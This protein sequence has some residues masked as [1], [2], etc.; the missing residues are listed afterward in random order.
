[1]ESSP[2]E[3]SLLPVTGLVLLAAVVGTVALYQDPL[4]SS[5]PT[6]PTQHEDLAFQR[7]IVQARLWEDPFEAVSLHLKGKGTNVPNEGSHRIADVIASLKGLPV[8]ANLSVDQ[9]G[10]IIQVLSV[11]VAGA[12][13]ADAGELRL[14][15]RY[16]VVS[17][18]G[19]AGYVP[20]DEEHIHYFKIGKAEVEGEDQWWLGQDL[21]VPYEIY[22]RDIFNQRWLSSGGKT[23]SRD[24]RPADYIVVL[25]LRNEVL[26]DQP[27]TLLQ[28]LVCKLGSRGGKASQFGVIGPRNS[29]TLRKMLVNADTGPTLEP[30]W[31]KTKPIPIYS[32]WSEAPASNLTLYLKDKKQENETSREQVRR[33]FQK[34]G[35]ELIRPLHTDDR[36]AEE[37]VEELIRR[38][39]DVDEREG[40]HHIVLVSE[41]DTFYGRQVPLTLK[42]ELDDKRPSNPDRSGDSLEPHVTRFTYLRG[43]DGHLPSQEREDSDSQPAT[44]QAQGES[45]SPESM[46]ERPEG[47]SQLDYLRRLASKLE[48]K[49]QELLREGK[50]EIRAI[51]ILGSDVYDKL[52]ITQALHKSFPRALFFTTG[53]DAQF[54]HP[55]EYPWCRNLII[56]STFG[57]ELTPSI[58]NGIPPFRSSYQTSL[59]LSTLT[60]IGY[61]KVQD[62]AAKS[63]LPWVFSKD[64][65]GQSHLQESE[66]KHYFLGRPRIFEIGRNGPFDLSLPTSESELKKVTAMEPVLEIHPTRHDTFPGAVVVRWFLLEVVALAL[67]ILLLILALC[68]ALKDRLVARCYPRPDG[69]VKTIG[70]SLG[71][72]L[73]FVV[74]GFLFWNTDL[75][76]QDEPFSFTDG[77]SIWP[78]EFLR[79]VVVLASVLLMV[80]AK[81]DLLGNDRDVAESFGLRKRGE[82]SDFRDDQLHSADHTWWKVIRAPVK[83][84]LLDRITLSG[85]QRRGGKLQ[86][87]EEVWRDYL[88]WGSPANRLI[89]TLVSAMLF[90]GI[91]GLII[92][93]FGPPNHPHRGFVSQWVDLVFF[94]AGIL[95]LVMLTFFI[96]DATLL[97]TKFIKLLTDRLIIWPD[98]LAKPL[99]SAQGMGKNPADQGTSSWLNILVVRDHSKALGRLVYFPFVAVF[100]AVLAR[101][102]YFDH[103]N[104]PV[105][106]NIIF[107]LLLVFALMC[108]VL[109]RRTAKLARETTV[110][111]IQKR[112][113]QIE[114]QWGYPHSLKENLKKM[115]DEI[116][117]IREGAF[118]PLANH[119]I[120]RALI[121]FGTLATLAVTEYFT[122]AF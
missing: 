105:G 98:F 19:V 15:S 39:L 40:K 42:D 77:I 104:Y 13:Y 115:V 55:A 101:H 69:V 94:G 87:I 29:G 56:A 25:W 73:T 111:A 68:P 45:L 110:A 9:D 84:G 78:T 11:M 99:L 116:E 81:K 14:R 59:F 44:E 62:S 114:S 86:N 8:P 96:V 89:R 66:V 88:L 107:A 58:Q 113:E 85:M 3:P 118:A 22:R 71:L 1:M 48:L 30:C 119:P 122:G 70:A 24:S 5:R 97:S 120:L 20:R 6:S 47:N 109:L 80:K 121:A 112:M 32:P 54:A 46:A 2:K 108:A 51:G 75:Y 65:L 33:L 53:L 79:F 35:W 82:S 28:E 91:V 23:E 38:D 37:L 21:T 49:N 41:W 63:D 34:H 57:L 117:D 27:L 43:L 100:G 93:L 95:S 4:K 26:L 50:A 16:A 61:V 7:E 17:A 31:D 103:W 67:L 18:L 36:L 90:F 12:S 76:L 10:P 83:L 52:L 102:S 106:L 64:S 60:A 74:A 92:C 72:V